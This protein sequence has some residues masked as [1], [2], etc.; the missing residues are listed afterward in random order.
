MKAQIVSFNC[1][2]K[3][4]LGQVLSSSFN[5]D[6][7]NQL[8]DAKLTQGDRRLRGLIEGL[9]N[10]S[11]GEKR[12]IVVPA[13]EAY[14]PYDP[15]LLLHVSRSE[16]MSDGPLAVGKEMVLRSSPKRG[17]VFRLVE[18][19]GKNLV[20]DGNHPLAGLDLT[21]EIEVISARDAKSED[22][23]ESFESPASQYLH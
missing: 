23:E 22:F 2:L 8:E 19:Q 11:A 3:N 16:V 13:T 18:V 10:V 21:F 15:E 12:E 14:G 4:K 6:V 7:I 17:A 20:L 1:V 9:Q 5:R